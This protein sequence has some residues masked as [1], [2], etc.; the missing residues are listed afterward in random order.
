MAQP[1]YSYPISQGFKWSPANPGG[2]SGNDV[3]CPCGTPL[4]ALLPG[5]VISLGMEAWGGQI[6]IQC[7][8]PGIGDIVL[9]YLHAQGFPRGMAPGVAVSAGE[10]IAISGQP[11]PGAGYGSG[12]HVHFE[13][14]VG[15]QPPYMGHTGPS[16]PIDGKFLL[17]AANAGTLGDVGS[18]SGAPILDASAVDA[19]GNPIPT[20]ASWLGLPSFS[21]GTGQIARAPLSPGF[22]GVVEWI[23][24][25]EEIPRFDAN[26]M[27]GWAG[28]L[29]EAMFF[30]GGIVLLGF[31]VIILVMFN[32]SR[33]VVE[34]EMAVVG[35]V[36]RVAASAAALA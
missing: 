5:H 13:V 12:C 33:M 36:G 4:T 32:A 8:W 16:N 17:D 9:S 18:A 7:S 35:D 11:P 24:E 15:T 21:L 26:N 31:A 23:D 10:L 1:W 28:A 25:I 27:V 20:L 34:Q 14:S 22:L 3:P 29:T 19:A 6:N 30:R 2:H